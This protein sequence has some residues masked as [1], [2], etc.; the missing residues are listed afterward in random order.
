MKQL[1]FKISNQNFLIEFSHL[2]TQTYKIR[3][4]VLF[5][6]FDAVFSMLFDGKNKTGLVYPDGK[7]EKKLAFLLTAT[8]S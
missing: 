2:F 7:I 8:S 3:Y 5:R 6:D 4:K 1:H